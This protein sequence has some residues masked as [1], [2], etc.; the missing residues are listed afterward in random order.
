MYF[1]NWSVTLVDKFSRKLQ[2]KRS[3]S[4]SRQKRL[5]QYNYNGGSPQRVVRG[6]YQ[7]INLL[8]SRP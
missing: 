4:S 5:T 2:I 1:I 8:I 3:I 6:R 7:N